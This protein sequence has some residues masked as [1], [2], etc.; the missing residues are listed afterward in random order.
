[1]VLI[2]CVVFIYCIN[3][4]VTLFRS[5]RRI[6]S[7]YYCHILSVYIV[8]FLVSFWHALFGCLVLVHSWATNSHLLLGH[9]TSKCVQS[10]WCCELKVVGISFA[11]VSLNSFRNSCG[12]RYPNF[13]SYIHDSI[14]DGIDD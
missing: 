4:V 7:L 10:S 1:M 2:L 8:I 5:F 6:S 14:Y 9:P 11:I 13:I 12:F 3:V